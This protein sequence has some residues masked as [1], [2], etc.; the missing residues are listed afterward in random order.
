MRRGCGCLL[1]LLTLGALAGTLVWAATQFLGE[2]ELPRVAWTPADRASAERK[3]ASLRSPRGRPT[4]VVLTE[5]ELT[6]LL[7]TF[8]AEQEGRPTDAWIRL[9][10]PGRA[11]VTLRLPARALV[12]EAG[13]GPAV[14]LLPA[15]WLRRPLGLRLELSV[16]TV[17]DGHIRLRV[18]R[19]H[20]GRLPVPTSA[21][22]LVLSP[23]LLGLLRWSLPPGGE[24]IA[25]EPGRLVLRSTR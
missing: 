5:P 20:V 4:D 21:H 25:V 3:L 6:A 24:T 9:P 12:E 16:R 19:F 7:A 18:E 23:L 1:M 17:R 11:D 2:P 8:L 15:G 14:D 22:R 13:F 10:A